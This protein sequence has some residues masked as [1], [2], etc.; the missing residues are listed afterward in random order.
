MDCE[1]RLSK[2]DGTFRDAS[3]KTGTAK[4]RTGEPVKAHTA[5]SMGDKVCTI[6]ITELK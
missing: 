1:L 4:V 5:K 3:L 6:T 2:P